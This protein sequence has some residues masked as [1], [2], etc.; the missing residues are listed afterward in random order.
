M[1]ATAGL[2]FHG[3]LIANLLDGKGNE[4]KSAD[5]TVIAL[6]TALEWQQKIEL[7]GVAKR[8]TIQ[9][10]DHQGGGKDRGLLVEVEIDSGRGSS[11]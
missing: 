7:Q 8:I 10:F 4:I 3:K 5:L 6:Q 2:F 9:L 1:S 11:N